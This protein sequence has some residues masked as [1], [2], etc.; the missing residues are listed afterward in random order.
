MNGGVWIGISL[1]LLLAGGILL[2]GYRRKL[3]RSYTKTEKV[4]QDI[5]NRKNVDYS[6]TL[7]D[8][9]EDK[10][11][12]LSVKLS[13]QLLHASREAEEEKEAV[14]G[15]IGDISHQLKTPLSNIKMCTELLEDP[16]LTEGERLE[17][18]HR[19]REQTEKIQWLL[20][21][22]VKISRLE[23]GA[24]S[25]TPVWEG[26]KQTVADSV[27][28]VFAAAGEK[29]IEI[30]VQEFPEIQV[31][32][33]RKWTV[34]ALGNILE[35]AVK[36]SPRGSAIVIRVNVLELYVDIEIQDEGPGISQDEYNL[37][38]QRFYRGKNGEK[39][40]GS[41]LGLYLTQ[42]ILSK[43]KG[44]AAVQSQPGTGSCFHVMLPVDFLQDRH[45]IT[46]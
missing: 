5:L 32:H 3:E 43:E 19:I 23:T 30:Q 16:S 39:V 31:W 10:L 41:G 29:Q 28:S 35:N 27:A 13:G 6:E 42:L 25:F 45:K 2:A 11:V 46:F 18:L 8:T 1:L 22:L 38:F 24:I 17:F 21:Q 9:R 40:P 26:L 14:K 36:Y 44:Y 12:S 33:N 20:A 34:E 15:M 7:G 4:L 37:I